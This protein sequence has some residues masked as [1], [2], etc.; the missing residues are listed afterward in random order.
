MKNIYIACLALIAVV[1][2][3]TANAKSTINDDITCIAKSIY[4]EARGEPRNGKI[5]IAGVILNRVAHEKFPDTICEVV[6]QKNPL[7]FSKLITKGT[8]ITNWESWK[9]SL[10]LAE[11]IVRKQIIISPKFKALYFDEKSVKPPK[12]LKLHAIIGNH[13]F[14]I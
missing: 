12:G 1:L 11:K 14:Y 6:Y 10:D 8:P 2:V 3:N 4:W 9:D 7:Q 5:G 13:K